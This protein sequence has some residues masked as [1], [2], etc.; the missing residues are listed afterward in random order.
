MDTKS[1]EDKKIDRIYYELFER[2]YPKT[3]LTAVLEVCSSISA[4]TLLSQ[5]SKMLASN[6]AAVATL[7]L[8]KDE[9]TQEEEVSRWKTNIKDSEALV[10]E[11][12]DNV[13]ENIKNM[14]KVS[15]F[16]RREHS[17]IP[18][19]EAAATMQHSGPSLDEMSSKTAEN[20]HSLS[21]EAQ[22]IA[23]GMKD[24]LGLK[25][26]EMKSIFTST[27][28]KKLLDERIDFLSSIEKRDLTEVGTQDDS[29][30]PE[31][32][33][34]IREMLKE[35]S[36]SSPSRFAPCFQQFSR[37]HNQKYLSAQDIEL[38]SVANNLYSAE[39]CWFNYMLSLQQ[40][41]NDKKNFGACYAKFKP[42]EYYC[43]SQSKEGLRSLKD[44]VHRDENK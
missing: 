23:K 36:V 32:M 44:I 18:M 7:N 42:K 29:V 34:E 11:E 43:I 33:E 17:K 27:P 6:A 22:L 31:R 30:C 35:E 41:Q 15:I 21:Q 1:K 9:R 39:N 24:Y 2:T 10:K 28:G 20:S 40:C 3:S 14:E 19:A 16:R 12:V 8:D 4:L 37:F 25:A 38:V 13:R 5:R 26:E